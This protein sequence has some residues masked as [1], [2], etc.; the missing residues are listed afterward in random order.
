MHGRT[1][2]MRPQRDLATETSRIPLGNVVLDGELSLP[3]TAAGIVIFVH[4]SGS[5]RH[6]PRNR[7]V[8]AGLHGDGLGTLLFDLLT[9][10]EEEAERFTRAL[11][12][13]ISLLSSRLVQVTEWL[14]RRP[15]AANLPIGYFGASTG[16]AAALRAA[17]LAPESVQ[18]VVS[19][20]GRSDLTGELLSQVRAP[21]LLIVGAAD[22]V[23][24]E[25]NRSAFARLTCPKQLVLVP[26]AT[27]LFEER[28]ALEQVTRL[29]SGWFGRCLRQSSH[30]AGAR[31]AQRG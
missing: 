24:I 18:A 1:R 28:G 30:P 16:A 12:F 20:G 2:S 11:R 7:Q 14:C 22:P 4:G 29:A 6:S 15:G 17:A 9:P 10:E 13:D 25:L 19:R 27:H 26:N 23:V 21:T 5:S 3:D 31:P 8:A